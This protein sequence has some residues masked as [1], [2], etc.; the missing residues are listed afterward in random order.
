MIR[1][2]PN[3]VLAEYEGDAH[4]CGVPTIPE[5]LVPSFDEAVDQVLDYLWEDELECFG[6]QFDP[7]AT[8]YRLDGNY[9]QSTRPVF[10]ALL[11]LRRYQ[12]EREVTS[13]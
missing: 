9:V 11:A 5:E 6:A 13:E 4:A 1:M 7:W 2:D 8:D 10:L 12:L 3:T